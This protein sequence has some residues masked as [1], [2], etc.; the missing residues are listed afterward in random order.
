VS[1]PLPAEAV[2]AAALVEAA[3]NGMEYRPRQDGKTWELVRKDRKLV[4]HVNPAEAGRPELAELAALLNLVPGA[5]RYELIVS[6]TVVFDPLRHPAAP[7]TAV[8]AQPRST[9][10]VWYF[11]SNGVEVPDE[12][13]RCGLVR[14][15]VNEAGQP[16]DARAVTEGLFTVHACKGHRRPPNA[17]VALHYRDYWYYIDDSDAQSKAT[18]ALV[19]QLSRL[20]F[21]QHQHGGPTLTLPVGR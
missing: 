12:H 14:L 21:G 2:T 18:F 7:T 3:K 6:T 8:Y 1:G 19:L 9:A 11:L 4:V 20:D 13:V 17:F 5:G 10:Q 16:F 15:P